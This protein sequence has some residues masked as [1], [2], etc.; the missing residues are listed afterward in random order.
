[1]QQ[2]TNPDQIAS[3]RQREDSEV[4]FPRGAHQM[5]AYIYAVEGVPAE[6]KSLHSSLIDKMADG[7]VEPFDAKSV[8]LRGHDALDKR[9]EAAILRRRVEELMSDADACCLRA[10]YGCS[11]S[12]ST[13]LA[14]C[15][16]AVHI[17]DEFS[18][19]RTARALLE[20]NGEY[21]SRT[22]NFLAWRLP[23]LFSESD[24]PCGNV[25]FAEPHE[26]PWQHKHVAA[27]FIVNR[28]VSH[29]LVRHRPMSF[30]QES[31]R[32]CRY[33]DEVAFIRPEWATP[34]DTAMSMQE[35]I[36]I[37]SVKRSENAY[38]NLLK[39]GLK[40]QQARAVLP[41]S[42]KTELIAYASLPQWRHIFNLRCSPAADPEMIRVMRPLREEF[43]QQYP[44]AFAWGEGW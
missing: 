12:R 33:E 27:R 18:K 36:W 31:Q 3:I 13:Q 23:V 32:Y 42:T 35:A 44:E 43:M 10:K 8:N 17:W 41:N 2:I 25:R 30:L 14:V 26:I 29:E 28:A 5:L 38:R 7:E 11:T 16:A 1:M 24:H 39:N 34:D 19:R 4:M 40:P 37:D 21:G 6:G 22:W 15:V 20:A 9:A